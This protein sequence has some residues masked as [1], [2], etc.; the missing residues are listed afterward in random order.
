[1]ATKTILVTINVHTSVDNEQGKQV[2]VSVQKWLNAV[3]TEVWK[4]P[5]LFCNLNPQSK[6]K[7]S[8]VYDNVCC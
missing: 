5:L 4:P 1:M 2:I 6:I 8:R 7:L 3:L